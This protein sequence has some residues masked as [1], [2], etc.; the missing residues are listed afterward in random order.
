MTIADLERFGELSS[1]VETLILER[2]AQYA[3]MDR[4]GPA[5]LAQMKSIVDNIVTRQDTL[6]PQGQA[7]AS[8][9]IRIVAIAVIASALLGATLALS[10]GRSI[11]RRLESITSSMTEIANGNLEVEVARSE[12][13]HEIG[14][15]TN[16]LVV[17]L[18]NARRARTLD[19][20]LKAKAEQERQLDAEMR[21]RE[22]QQA[23]EKEQARVAE[24][25]KERIHSE[26]V[27]AFQ[28]LMEDVLGKAGEGDFAVRMPEGHSDESMRNLSKIVNTLLNAIQSNIEDVV[29]SLNSLSK[30][31]LTVRMTGARKGSFATMQQDFNDALG[32][33]SAT[34]KDIAGSSGSVAMT[35]SE[36]ESASLI[37]SRR[38]E[39]NASALEEVSAAIDEISKSVRQVVDSTKAA[40]AATKLVREKAGQSREVANQTEASINGITEASARINSVVKVIEDIAFQINLLALNAGVEAARAGEAGRGFSVVA[41]EVRALAQ[42]SQ[43]AV[44]EI[45]QVIEENNKSV[46]NGVSQVTKSRE[47]LEDIVAKVEETA[48]QIADITTA[49]EEQSS[50]IEDIRAT[51]VT[52]DNSAQA[53]AASLEELT[54]SN[55]TLNQEAN[56]LN[57]AVSHFKIEDS[58]QEQTDGLTHGVPERI[59]S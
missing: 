53:S 10:T 49:V 22:A 48:Q 33:L 2:N 20:E 55:V 51:V 13:Q 39:K 37:M 47:A 6:G 3:E 38:G 5:V 45:G 46:H 8:R 40:N 54:A 43:E 11:R 7:K 50:G 58:H 27:T 36:L 21:E 12:Q 41:S 17:F 42:R 30:G 31:N 29:Q 32:S 19:K 24:R 16:A 15:M 25:E 26:E 59:A 35:A 18:E 28:V 4:I 23:S 56:S 44:Q 57:S 1:Q 9:A 14:K 52:L 34:M